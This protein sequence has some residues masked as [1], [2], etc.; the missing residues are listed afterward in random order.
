MAI[1]RDPIT[2][3]SPMKEPRRGCFF[4]SNAFLKAPRGPDCM[5][6][7][8]A[9]SPMTPEKPIRMTKMIYGIRKAAPQN[10]PARYGKSQILAIPTELPIQ[11]MIKPHLLLN[12][13]SDILP[14][15][16]MKHLL[17]FLIIGAAGCKGS[18][19]GPKTVLL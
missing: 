7:P 3:I 6:R 11:E 16:F 12:L 18:G 9:I 13:S 8:K 5:A 17:P 4:I 1:P 14:L 15:D 2:G 19:T 10:S